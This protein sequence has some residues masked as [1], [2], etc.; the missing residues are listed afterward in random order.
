M[1][2]V[3]TPKQTKPPR[4]P[5]TAKAPKVDKRATTA[6]PAAPGSRRARAAANDDATQFAPSQRVH[7]VARVDLIP[8]SVEIRR[9]QRRTRRLLLAG[10]AGLTAVAVVAGLGA[11]VLAFGAEKALADE[12]VRHTQLMQEQ[13]EY[14]EVLT[15]KGR[16]SDYDSARLA[17]LY[18]EADWARL[19]RELDAAMP[20]D[21]TLTTETITVRGGSDSGPVG[22]EVAID[23]QGVI[24]ITFAAQGSGFG[25]PTP[26]LNA[27][28][29]LTG[30]VSANVESVVNSDGGYTI[31]GVVRLDASA[32]GGTARVNAL[33]ADLVDQLHEALQTA[34]T[35]PPADSSD[36]TDSEE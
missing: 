20:A 32:L 12:Q 36:T 14:S 21:V 13:Q 8:P 9:K 1:A 6:A 2:L 24:E 5:K 28:P 35:T 29:S 27:L 3:K 4:A 23:A 11:A 22:Q 26:M 30:Y 7:A 17:A 31:T 34:L 16:L 33:D 19:M 15:V 10:L 18:P 25:S